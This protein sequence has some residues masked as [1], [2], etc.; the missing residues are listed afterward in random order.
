MKSPRHALLVRIAAAP[1]LMGF[2]A[3]A[4]AQTPLTI[5]PSPVVINVPLQQFSTATVTIAN[6]QTPVSGLAPA[7]VEYGSGPSGWL[8]GFVTAA[9]PGAYTVT[10]Y[11]GALPAGTYT[12]TLVFTGTTFQQTSLEI[13]M[14]VGASPASTLAATPSQLTFSYTAGG[15]VTPAQQAVVVSST[16]GN[17]GVTISPTQAWLIVS[18]PSGVTPVTLT[19]SINP[20]FVSGSGTLSGAVVV[21][22]AAGGTP[23][24]IPVSLQVGCA[25]SPLTAAPSSLTYDVQVGGSAVDKT[26]DITS[27]APLAVSVQ[28]SSVSWLT[29]TANQLTTP[30]RLTVRANQAGLAA[31]PYTTNIIVTPSTGQPL[32]IGVTLN[33]GALPQVALSSSLVNLA[34]QTGTSVAP[35][36]TVTVTTGGATLAFLARPPVGTVWPSWLVVSPLSG[37]TVNGQIEVSVASS[38]LAGL[39]QGSYSAEIE[40]LV[41]G[42]QNPSQV[43]RVSLQ[44]SLLPLLMANLPS[45]IFTQPLGGAAPPSQNFHITSSSQTTG[46]T[47]LVAATTS[48]GGN[49]L[50]VSPA[51]AVTPATLTASLSSVAST[52]IPGTYNGAINISSS[53]AG[54]P[55]TM[56]VV[57]RVTND[58]VLT[59]SAPALTFN[60]QTGKTPPALQTIQ[61]SSTGAPISFTVATSLPTGQ[62]WLVVVPGAT[63]TP[64]TLSVVASTA[65]MTPGKYEGSIVVTAQGS[66][67]PSL[68]I[69]VTYNVSDSALLN[70]GAPAVSFSYSPSG[71]V[72]DLQML[73]LTSTD[74]ANQLNFTV[75]FST[76]SGFPWVYVLPQAG[77][78]PD[79]IRVGVQPSSLATGVHTGTVTVKA[80]GANTTA[81]PV[82]LTIGTAA[83]NLT[84]NPTQLAFT[85]MSGGAAPAAQSILVGTTGTQPVSFSASAATTLGGAWLSVTPSAG[86]TPATLGVTA[87]GAPGGVALL[88]GTYNGEVTVQSGHGTAPLRIPVVFTITQAA[89]I[90]V[91]PG[92][93]AFNA[94][95]GAAAPAAQTLS[96]TGTSLPFTVEVSTTSGGNWLAATPATAT[97][98]ANISVSVKIDNLAPGSYTGQVSIKSPTASNSP[99]NVTVTLVV[100]GVTV[101]PMNTV[102]N[103][104]TALP[105]PLAP[106]EIISIKGTGLGPA[107]G[108]ETQLD[109]QGR[110]ATTLAETRALFD[111]FP[112][113][114]TFVRTDQINVV[115]PYEVAGRASVRV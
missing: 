29:M 79:N 23:L 96:V 36:Q 93:L 83:A 65:G 27:T 74:P 17:V 66:S 47:F 59:S 84:A 88:P 53:A 82:T 51:A 26:V 60:F 91:S 16:A 22:P 56:P 72:P 115:V 33:V 106:G 87:S 14:V 19:I 68:T 110:V 61:L 15:T 63:T 109:A 50:L 35:R 103:A 85:Q 40:I 98:P 1:L 102:I 11:A 90:A 69:P 12:V 5:N 13:R 41:P 8:V 37:S 113:A 78:T 25:L 76:S 97:T 67:T 112:G 77:R 81:V 114:L 57:L 21:T 107:T 20:V 43:V 75:E 34:Y 100:T 64:S 92:T 44:V 46:L 104:A 108:V 71:S 3:C 31:G 80:T 39:A 89:P 55:L 52:L 42:A 101:G 73:S 48:S 38:A 9:Q 58:P 10:A 24:Q 94:Q 32:T 28:P 18:T 99:Q 6:G 86:T 49:W 7:R 62:N 45:L 2:A 4:T 54:N 95:I 105:G 70:V 111:G 30:L